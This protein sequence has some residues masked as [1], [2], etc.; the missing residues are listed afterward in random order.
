MQGMICAVEQEFC[1]AGDG[2][3]F[4]D[5]QPVSVD[6]VVVQHIVFLE[7]S[8]I[9]D[10]IVVEGERSDFDHGIVHN[11]FQKY[12]LRIPGPGINFTAVWNSHKD[13]PFNV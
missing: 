5:P 1:P 9:M 4:S 10:K 7:I 6:G 8:R 12:G 2:T 3:E 11:V 13:L